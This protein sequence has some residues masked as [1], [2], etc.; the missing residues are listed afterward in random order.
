MAETTPIVATSICQTV[1]RFESTNVMTTP[2][3]PSNSS[4]A[5]AIPSS[6]K[7]NRDTGSRSRRAPT[8]TDGFGPR[9]DGIAVRG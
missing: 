9:R 1:R 7:W 3:S 2:S 8:S 4:D 5:A 6:T